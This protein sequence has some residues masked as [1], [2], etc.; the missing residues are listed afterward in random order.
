MGVKL[1]IKLDFSDPAGRRHAASLIDQMSNTEL[2]MAVLRA[3]DHAHK[4][5]AEMIENR[6][7][8][9]AATAQLAGLRN[10]VAQLRALL[11]EILPNWEKLTQ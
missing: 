4:I 5:S 8:A 10:D 11:D 2:K 7:M 3:I 6:A 9:D 1:D